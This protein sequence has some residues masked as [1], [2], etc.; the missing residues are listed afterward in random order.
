MCHQIAV[1]YGISKH[2][3]KRSI[4]AS[5]DS[6]RLSSLPHAKKA[7][8]PRCCEKC[9]ARHAAHGQSKMKLS[10]HEQLEK[11]FVSFSER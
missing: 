4:G 8:I 6:G 1:S 11:M 2:E 5:V 10:G 9:G 3:L 7:N